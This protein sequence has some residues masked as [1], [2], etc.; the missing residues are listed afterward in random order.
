MGHIAFNYQNFQ[1]MI[2]LRCVMLF[3][4]KIYSFLVTSLKS[5]TGDRHSWPTE[6]M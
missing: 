6:E 3:L 4:F 1:V 5:T 2:H